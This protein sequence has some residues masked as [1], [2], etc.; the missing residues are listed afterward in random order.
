MDWVETW[1]DL[2]STVVPRLGSRALGG[3]VSVLVCVTGGASPI[4]IEVVKLVVS[5]SAVV[6]V[7]VAVLV[8]VF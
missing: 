6:V 8:S 2:G 3:V 7:V 4:A 1:D 5:V